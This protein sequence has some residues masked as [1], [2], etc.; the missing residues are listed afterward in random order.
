MS[1]NQNYPNLFEDYKPQFK[2]ETGL[3]WSTN[4]QVYIQYVQAKSQV[5]IMQ[6]LTDVRNYTLTIRD[7]ISTISFQSQ[8]PRKL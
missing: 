3:E 8:P 2:K 5:L 1:T 6:M 7:S 4:V